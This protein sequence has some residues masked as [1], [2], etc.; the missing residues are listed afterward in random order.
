[1]EAAS[2]CSANCRWFSCSAGKGLVALQQRDVALGVVPD[3]GDQLQAIGS[4]TT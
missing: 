3:S 1:L 2:I 4:L